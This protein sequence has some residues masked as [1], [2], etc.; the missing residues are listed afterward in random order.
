MQQALRQRITQ[1]AY[2][3]LEESLL[4]Y[5]LI[6]SH[7]HFTGACLIRHGTESPRHPIPLPTKT[8]RSTSKSPFFFGE[9][10]SGAGLP[11]HPVVKLNTFKG[12]PFILLFR[13]NAN[14]KAGFS[15]NHQLLF[16]LLELSS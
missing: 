9:K 12:V 5:L 3:V 2:P 4:A 7:L 6:I 1:K 16:W 15:P 14:I 13:E 11:H 8:K 10:E